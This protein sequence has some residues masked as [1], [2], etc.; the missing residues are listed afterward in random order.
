MIHCFCIRSNSQKALKAASLSVSPN[1]VCK[2]SRPSLSRS[3]LHI[4]FTLLAFSQLA[5]TMCFH[6][7]SHIQ[8]T[9]D[10]SSWWMEDIKHQ[11]VAPFHPNAQNYRVFR[12]VKV[13]VR[14]CLAKRQL[15]FVYRTMALLEMA[16]MTILR[17][18]S[19][20]SCL[21]HL[22]SADFVSSRAIV[23]G[24]RCGGGGCQSSTSVLPLSTQ[25]RYPILLVGFPLRLFT[26]RPGKHL[27]SA[28]AT[29][30]TAHKCLPCDCPDH[31]VLLHST[32]R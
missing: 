20:E 4:I 23:D 25:V 15:S 10:H 31:P 3:V 1:L 13:G 28:A 14:S 24:G 6:D 8:R 29:L 12:N 5:K 30:L 16:Y 27:R 26:F 7:R 32:H 18:S 17:Q 2:M 9:S 21:K 19:P 11:G 22:L